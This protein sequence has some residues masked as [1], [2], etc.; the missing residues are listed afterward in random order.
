MMTLRSDLKILYHL[1]L[2]PI[3]G[4]DHAQRMEDFYRGQAEHYDRFPRAIAPRPRGAVPI[5]AR[6][7]RRR[8]GRSGRRNGGQPRVA[9]RPN[10]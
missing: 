8:L 9:R 2:R 6:P 1:A 5:D 4:R 10:P 3:R 7:G